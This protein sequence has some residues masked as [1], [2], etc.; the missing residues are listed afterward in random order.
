VTG[1]ERARQE[2]RDFLSRDEM[3]QGAI[4]IGRGWWGALMDPGGG[5]SGRVGGGAMMGS[6][7]PR[8]VLV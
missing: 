7:A 2:G 8:A 3:T 1:R 5:G 4:I 6:F